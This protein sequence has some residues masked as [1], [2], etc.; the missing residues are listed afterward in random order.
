MEVS[1]T[2]EGQN[3][4]IVKTKSLLIKKFLFQIF[5]FFFFACAKFLQN[6]SHIYIRKNRPEVKNI[7]NIVPSLRSS[8]ALPPFPL[9]LFFLPLPQ[10]YFLLFTVNLNVVLALFSSSFTFDYQL[11]WT[12][13]STPSRHRK[14]IFVHFSALRVYHRNLSQG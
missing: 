4:F 12:D 6:P 5:F 10:P 14:K 1:A 8:P 13:S 2:E 3:N 9:L 7:L 11:S